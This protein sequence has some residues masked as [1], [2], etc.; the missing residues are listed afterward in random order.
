MNNITVDLHK[1]SGIT[2]K[3]TLFGHNLEHTRSAV[4]QGLSAQVL[5]NRKFAGKPA[6]HFGE[7]AEWYRIGPGNIYITL[8]PKDAYV[9]HVR[10]NGKSDNS[11]EINSLVIQNPVANQQAGIGQKNLALKKGGEYRIKAVLKGRGPFPFDVSVRIVHSVGGICAEKSFA[12]T[13]ADWHPYD[14]TFVMPEDDMNAA[15]EICFTQ[16]AEIKIGVVSLL[17]V[18]NFHGMRRDVIDLMKQIGISLLRWPGGNFAGEYNWKDGL[19][20][21]DMRAPQ[22]SYQPVETQ[23]HSGGYDFHEI[24]IDEFV[25]LCKEI[26]AEPY[27]TINLAWDSPEESAQWVEYCNGSADTEW[28]GIRTERGFAEPYNVR[29]WSLGNEFGYGHMEGL[30]TPESYAEKARLSAAVMK[31]IDGDLVFFASGPYTPKKDPGPWTREGLPLLAG[32]IAYVSYHAYQWFFVHGV[33]FVTDEGL[34]K[35]YYDVCGAPDSWLK[36][37]KELRTMLD[38]QGEDIKK[39]GI[40]FDEWNVFFAW[41]HNPCVIEGMFTALMLEMICR[42]Y[43]GLNMPICMYFQPVNEGAIMVYPLESELTANGQVFKL[44]KEH[45]EGNM[46]EIHSSDEDIHCLGT[47][48]RRSGK[49]FVT[50]INRAYDRD[51]LCSFGNGLPITCA[52]LLDGSGPVFHG[53]KWKETN[54][55]DIR[56]GDGNFVIPRRSIW[57][58]EIKL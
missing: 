55:L 28:G 23:P 49:A 1:D 47:V 31:K 40:A 50:L 46:L 3:K 51:V 29:Y 58:A 35:S 44:M 52:V 7:P 9:R 36:H 30:N 39:I 13:A 10:D 24:G 17:P 22:L 6:A 37:L 16:R 4:F 45:A 26:G 48:H 25:A 56:N 27:L 43:A 32:D 21:A 5:R 34:R 18:D 15:V 12:V 11:N 53:S 8:D 14:F 2:I 19:L 41:Y 57:Q 20:D 33:D 54:G 42:E 38:S